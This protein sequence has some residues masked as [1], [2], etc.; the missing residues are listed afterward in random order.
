[1][2][3]VSGK[4]QFVREPADAVSVHEEI[5]QRMIQAIIETREAVANKLIDQGHSPAVVRLH[6]D[7]TFDQKRGVWTYSCT[8]IFLYSGKEA[9]K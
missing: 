7:T 4:P 6:E 2:I 3:E 8:P 9:T 5:R 1:M